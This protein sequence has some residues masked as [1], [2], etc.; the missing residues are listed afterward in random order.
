M[1]LYIKVIISGLASLNH[2]FMLTR[3]LSAYKGNKKN[4][5]TKLFIK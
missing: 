3:R 2:V 5:A 1:A 4:N